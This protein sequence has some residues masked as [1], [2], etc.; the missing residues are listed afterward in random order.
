[1]KSTERSFGLNEVERQLNSAENKTTSKTPNEALHD[2]QP[3]FHT[4]VLGSLSQNSSE[5]KDPAGVQRKVRKN[6]VTEQHRMADCYNRKHYQGDSL[7]PGEVVVMLKA[8]TQGQP[9]KLQFKYREKLLQVIEKLPYDI[10]R[11]AEIVPEG[12]ST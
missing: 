5:W 9:S 2:Y 4:G 1:L 10:Y 3:R 8:P 11:V 6:I 12:Q 7:D